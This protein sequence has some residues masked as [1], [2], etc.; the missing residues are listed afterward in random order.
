MEFVPFSSSRSPLRTVRSFFGYLSRCQMA[1]PRGPDVR[2]HLVTV[3]EE[4][5][6]AMSSKWAFVSPPEYLKR[7]H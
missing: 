5:G 7:K 6:N 4:S 1:V 3:F 2:R